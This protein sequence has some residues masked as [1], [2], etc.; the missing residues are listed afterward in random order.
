MYVL[1]LLE[2]VVAADV[3]SVC[4]YYN[5][6]YFLFA[7]IVVVVAAATEFIYRFD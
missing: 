4:G 3:Y 2:G 1:F 6:Y 7:N 5:Y